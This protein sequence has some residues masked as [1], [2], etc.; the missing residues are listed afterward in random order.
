MAAE[1]GG[2]VYFKRENGFHMAS[3]TLFGN[4]AQTGNA[5]A[6]LEPLSAVAP[7]PSATITNTI[8]WDG[9]EEI[10]I[11]EHVQ[12]SVTYSDIQSGW[13]GE[14]N[15]DVD[16]LFADPDNGDFH[17]KSQAGRWDAVTRS[18]VVDDVTSPCID[19]GDPDSPV[20]YE[21]EPNGGRVNMGAYG[22][23]AEASMS[24]YAEPIP[25]LWSDP[26]PLA[27]VNLDSA[28]EWSPVLSADGLTLYFGRV[29]AVDQP[30]GRIFQATRQSTQ[31]WSRFTGVAEIPGALNQSAG[32]VLC[33]WISPDG[34][35]MYYTLQSGSVFRLMV[36]ERPADSQLWPAGTEIH[37]LNQLDH[38]LHT[39]RLTADELTI[40]FTGPRIE[41]GWSDYDI[42]MATRPDRDAPF[43]DPVNLATI[44]SAYNDIHASPSSD[45]LTLYFASNRRGRYHLFASTRE[46][47]EA[48]F[49]PPVHM[50]RFDTPD[51]HSMFPCLALDSTEFYFMR[52]TAGGRGTRDIWVSYRID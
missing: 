1:A 51:G 21:P 22:G 35:R 18:W 34:L 44:N 17:L 14:G 16:P 45:G 26:V 5:I 20:E 38:R 25:E 8:L 11:A 50:A 40:F 30:F 42:W 52:E 47:Q 9:G 24:P 28:E 12:M 10:S 41:G 48:P 27:E 32:D 39:C 37:E 29:C 49:G 7:A 2:A 6:C 33:P 4:M 13:P 43:D 3:C 46:S 36:S 19:T 15:I 23:T 31:P